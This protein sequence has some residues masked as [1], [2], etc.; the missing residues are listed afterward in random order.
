MDYSLENLSLAFSEH[1]GLADA[2]RY[3]MI[4][5]WKDD[6]PGEHL[7]EHLASVFNL[8][9]AMKCIVDE[10]I[11]LKKANERLTGQI[12]SIEKSFTRS[13]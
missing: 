4:V 13:K 8:A 11:A 3:V 1:A 5:K 10:L 2:Q 6:H 7:P 12:R 9:M